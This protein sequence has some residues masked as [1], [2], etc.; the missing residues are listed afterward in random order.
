M[1]EPFTIESLELT[2]EALQGLS[3]RK[4]KPVDVLQWVSNNM[5]GDPDMASCPGMVALTLMIDCRNDST[6]RVDFWKSMYT[7]LIPSR[8]QVGL[9]DDDGPIDGHLTHKLLGKI[10]AIRDAAVNGVVAGDSA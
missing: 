8:A 5:N 10:M 6:F 9:D 2:D 1:P 3:G 7:K 4:P